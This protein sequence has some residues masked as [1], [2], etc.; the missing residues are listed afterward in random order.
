MGSILE[1][2]NCHEGL[3]TNLPGIE[4]DLQQMHIR[5]KFS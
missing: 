5:D 2:G 3:G 1:N 4:I